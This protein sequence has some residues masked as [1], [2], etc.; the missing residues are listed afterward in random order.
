MNTFINNSNF[1]ELNRSEEYERLN[2]LND[3]LDNFKISDEDMNEN[4]SEIFPSEAKNT[5]LTTN[6]CYLILNI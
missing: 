2:D 5:Y 3:E 6:V 1:V 4:I